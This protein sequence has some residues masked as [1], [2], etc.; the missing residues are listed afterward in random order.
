MNF[1]DIPEQEL[2]RFLTNTELF[3]E[4]DR[5]TLRFLLPRL[6]LI[7]L[8]FNQVLMSQG[9]PGDSLYLIQS[10]KLGIV[11]KDDED[12]EIVVA[13]RLVN[14]SVGEIAL[15]TGE[16]RSAKV[17]AL[18]PARLIRLS[19]SAFEDLTN[20]HPPA[21]EHITGAIIQR[22]QQSQLQQVLHASKLFEGLS[23]NALAD[24]ESRLAVTMLNSGDHLVYEGEDSD[25]LHIIISGRLQVVSLL[26][27]GSHKVWT[28]LGRGQTVGEMGILTGEKRSASVLALRDTLV[29]RLS[30][31]SFHWLMAAHPD[32]MTRK[33]AG[34]IVKRLWNQVQ[35]ASRDI[36]TLATFTVVPGSHSARL[37]EFCKSLCMALSD[38]GPTLHINSSRLDQMLDKKGVAQ[39]RTQDASNINLVRWLSEQESRYRYVIY[40][41]DVDTT[42]WTERCLRQAD[43]VLMVCQPQSES[44]V[45]ENPVLPRTR[46]PSGETTLVLMHEQPHVNPVNT[47]FWL[48]AF[49]PERHHHIRRLNSQDYNRLARMLTGNSV[50]LVLSGGGARGLAHIGVIRAIEE[51]GMNIDLIGGTSIGGIMAAQYAMGWNS[52]TMLEN[53]KRVISKNN[54]LQYTLPI[55]SI[56]TG[57]SWKNFIQE[58]F[59]DIRIEDLWLNYF[60]CSTNLTES[61]LNIHD[62]GS[63]WKAA[64]ASSS[65]PGIIPPFYNHG[66]LLVDGA[67][68]NNMPVDIMRERNNGG[69]IYAV[70]VGSDGMKDKNFTEFE[71]VLSGWKLF[72]RRQKKNRP[73]P[74]IIS[75]LMQSAIM[76]SQL[77]QQNTQRMADLYI[78]PDVGDY[79]LLNFDVVDQVAEQGYRCAVE[80]ISE[81]REEK[82]KKPL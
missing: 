12:R 51:A 18:A 52:E 27:D 16:K 71:P 9:D 2:I 30:K 22:L 48:D 44:E 13:E 34:S 78:N 54:K 50:G 46:Q 5:E 31:E 11:I 70:D 55:I 42:P 37:D 73:V 14:E 28:E 65:I 79:S 75:I 26:Q 69:S 81:W 72:F 7:H 38:F 20:E 60:C 56:L 35:G 57:A 67:V 49:K 10:G 33:F 8:S 77:T 64:R 53:T 39:T 62:S 41:A 24:L 4:L 59:G 47:R 15:L 74:G 82:N 76:G 23:D 40:Q 36:N 66:R 58:L 29:A 80:K 43:R 63:L 68:L 61:R 45:I 17:I 19:K 32:M 1:T 25:S 21:L 3:S 6:E